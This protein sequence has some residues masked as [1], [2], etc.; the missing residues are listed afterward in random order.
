MNKKVVILII[1]TC[2]VLTACGARDFMRQYQQA[3]S[4]AAVGGEGNLQF[5][6]NK[7]APSATPP[8][9]QTATT[10][11]V[12]GDI[13]S[14]SG[15]HS[16]DNV[17]ADMQ[18]AQYWVDR[19]NTPDRVM[20]NMDGIQAYNQKTKEQLTADGNAEFYDLDSCGETISGDQ[21]KKLVS[22]ATYSLSAYY[23]DG[24]DVTTSQWQAYYA[25]CNY[26][27]IKDSQTVRYG[28][29]CKRAD[30]RGLPVAEF[31]C[32]E[33]GNQY[34]D[35]LQNTALAVNEPVLV[36]YTSR[37]GAWY[38]VMAEE[39][40]GWVQK[41]AVGL[42]S[43]RSEWQKAKDMTRFV[44]VTGDQVQ[45]RKMPGDVLSGDH[46][47]TMGTK[48]CLAEN[49]EWEEETT[50]YDCYVVRVPERKE[51][52]S[53]SYS[54]LALPVG[55]DIHI[56]YMEY[57]KANVVR[58][59][60]KMLGNPYGWGG[61]GGERDCSSMIRDI[62]RCFGFSLPRDSDDMANLTGET[63]MDL[64][65]LSEREKVG[66]LAGIQPGSILRMP[67][68]VMLYLGCVDRNYYVISARGGD[69]RQVTVN[70]LNALTE[71]QKTWLA[72]LTTVVGIGE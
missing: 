5:G 13:V 50:V 9:G 68:H 26:D 14:G 62:Y 18:T 21:L 49:R 36:L 35:M 42:C 38:Y 43:G 17:T 59:A 64:T 69:V 63:H 25:N 23:A 61:M 60:F 47:F 41:E 8:G 54:L 20:M 66:Q 71:D 11:S 12:M 56:G 51:D 52:G 28:I 37:D 67:G 46:V 16:A 48:L 34:N 29:V 7:A 1:A 31:I 44:V 30:V 55:K 27:A 72:Q 3:V 45:T 22:R 70:D 19:M 15:I 57:T 6:E 4:G 10:S 33:P 24:T 32:G 39:Y 58:Q 65:G 53:L 2:C 40:A